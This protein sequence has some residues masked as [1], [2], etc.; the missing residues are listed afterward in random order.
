MHVKWVFQKNII[1]S[2]KTSLLQK[3]YDIASIPTI[4]HYRD[5]H[6]FVTTKSGMYIT[7]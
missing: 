5:I 6:L 3:P 7:N 2:I 4:N 1:V